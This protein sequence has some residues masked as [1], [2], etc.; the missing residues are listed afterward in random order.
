MFLAELFWLTIVVLFIFCQCRGIDFSIA[1]HEVP[2]RSREI[3]SLVK[4][5]RI[6]YTSCL[7]SYD[8]YL[9]GSLTRLDD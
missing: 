4:K 2:N 9:N 8:I 6:L 7:V 3:P 1:N 5:V